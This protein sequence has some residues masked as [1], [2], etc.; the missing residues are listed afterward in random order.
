[1]TSPPTNSEKSKPFSLLSFAN[2]VGHHVPRY[3][4]I[5][6]KETRT[7]RFI[8]GNSP[9]SRR[10]IVPALVKVATASNLFLMDLEGVAISHLEL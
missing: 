7:T 9:A 3:E 1:M 10:D 6:R 5:E 2:A 4:R 8:G